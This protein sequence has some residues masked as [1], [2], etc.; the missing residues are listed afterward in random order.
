MHTIAPI[1]RS[2][3][4]LS[5]DD[6]RSKDLKH[7]YLDLYR[8]LS[9]TFSLRHP[10]QADEH[11]SLSVSWHYPI[12]YPRS[13]AL[14]AFELARLTMVVLRSQ[15]EELLH[16]D[17]ICIYVGSY[18]SAMYVTS[19]PFWCRNTPNHIFVSQRRLYG[20][21]ALQSYNYF[22]DFPKDRLLLRGMV[23]YFPSRKALVL[24]T[25][26]VP[27]RFQVTVLLWVHVSF[28]HVLMQSESTGY[29]FLVAD[30]WR[31][32]CHAY[33]HFQSLKEFVFQCRSVPVKLPLLRSRHSLG[34]LTIH[35]SF[36]LRKLTVIV[37]GCNGQWVSQ[38]WNTLMPADYQH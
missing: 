8:D 27:F 35:S 30:F 29:T 26:T 14:L 13:F 12:F 15:Q 5:T 23:R 6:Q 31:Q 17:F 22:R 36:H 9:E 25:L 37:Q 10:L 32:R 11:G 7:R 34:A 28:K 19:Y 24:V 4:V 38:P 20:I 1:V 21:T 3:V 16:I 18:L 33:P 2:L